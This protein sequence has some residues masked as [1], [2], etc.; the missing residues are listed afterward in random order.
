[1]GVREDE[2]REDAEQLLEALKISAADDKK[3]ETKLKIVEIWLKDMYDQGY[4]E[5]YG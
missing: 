1:M 5:A 3:Y 2:F 4:R